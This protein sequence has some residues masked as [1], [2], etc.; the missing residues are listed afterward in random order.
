ME[1]PVLLADALDQFK[2]RLSPIHIFFFVLIIFLQNVEGRVIF[3]CGF[4]NLLEP[5]ETVN[6]NLKIILE[7]VYRVFADRRLTLCLQNI[8]FCLSN[9]LLFR[10]YF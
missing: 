10:T 7:P 9:T 2:L 4:R 3:S 8:F 1:Q 6:G 5:R